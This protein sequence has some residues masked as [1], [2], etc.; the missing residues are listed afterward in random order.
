M[1]D[2]S[3]DWSAQDAADIPGWCTLQPGELPL[4][5]DAWDS[6]YPEILLLK[7]SNKRFSFT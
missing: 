3:R 6:D 7:Q 4:L 1:S 5:L 2:S